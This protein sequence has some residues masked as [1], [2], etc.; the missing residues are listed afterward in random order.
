MRECN[1]GSLLFEVR[2]HEVSTNDRARPPPMTARRSRPTRSRS[3]GDPGRWARVLALLAVM[4]FPAGASY[5][6]G[7]G[8]PKAIYRPA[9]G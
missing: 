5:S 3:R 9:V 6:S 8:S 7:A 1:L 2:V 4:L